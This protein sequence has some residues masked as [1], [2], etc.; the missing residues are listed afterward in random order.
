MSAPKFELSKPMCLNDFLSLP[1][2]KNDSWWGEWYFEAE[3]KLM[4]TGQAGKGKTLFTMGFVGAL[5]DQKPF[6]DFDTRGEHRCMYV[7]LELKPYS[8]KRRLEKLAKIYSY[9]NF[10][11]IHTVGSE[12]FDVVDRGFQDWFIAQVAHFK[13][14]V[15]VFDCLY[16]MH[17]CDDNEEKSMKPVLEAIN[18]IVKSTGAGLILL[19]HTPKAGSSPKGTQ[20]IAADMDT[21]INVHTT[22]RSGQGTTM[23]VEFTKTREAEAPDPI[24]GLLINQENL[25]ISIEPKEK[26]ATGITEPRNKL[27][28]HFKES[29]F[30]STTFHELEAF[31]FKR[32][33]IIK[34]VKR[35]PEH[36]K[37]DGEKV[38]L[39]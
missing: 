28:T 8:V 16:K 11:E 22:K 39:R 9:K 30:K 33:S 23:N 5:L 12:P 35:F 2:R 20:A 7:N 26:S 25:S 29:M 36:F 19:H 27:Y 31:G 4:V 32:D 10:Y 14:D 18:R 1:E 6:L 21:I 13:I 15:I 17:H 38:L 3:S 34:T 24:K 37:V